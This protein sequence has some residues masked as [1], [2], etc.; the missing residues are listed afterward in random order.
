MIHETRPGYEPT[1]AEKRAV[2]RREVFE[3]YNSLKPLPKKERD[4]EFPREAWKEIG[5]LVAEYKRYDKDKAKRN[6]ARA[7]RAHNALVLDP[8]GERKR[9]RRANRLSQSTQEPTFEQK[10]ARRRINHNYYEG[11]RDS[12]PEYRQV[13][14]YDLQLRAAEIEFMGHAERAAMVKDQRKQNGLKLRKGNKP[15]R[16]F[17]R[18]RRRAPEPEPVIVEDLQ[19]KALRAEYDELRAINHMR[20]RKQGKQARFEELRAYFGDKPPRPRKPPQPRIDRAFAARVL[21]MD[22]ALEAVGFTDRWKDGT[23][24]EGHRDVNRL[25]PALRAEY[26]WAQGIQA[27]YGVPGELRL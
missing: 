18:R 1:P 22:R 8:E 2:K 5:R 24:I 10:E 27:D 23:L 25:T 16:P 9:R 17:R 26:E 6:A 21:T 7:E 11:N 14:K 15:P 20:R 13:K 12:I 4:E 3:L 19:R